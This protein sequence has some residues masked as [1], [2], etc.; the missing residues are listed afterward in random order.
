MAPKLSAQLVGYDVTVWCHHSTDDHR[1]VAAALR[2]IFKKFVFQKEACPTT[3]THHWQIR[4]HLF[5]KLC[6]SSMKDMFL[7]SLWNGCVSPTTTGIHKANNFSYC[8]KIDSRVEGPWTDKDEIPARPPLTRQLRE[9]LDIGPMPWHLT[10]KQYAMELDN[11]TIHV[12][13]ARGNVCKSLW[14]EWMEFQGLGFEIP[15]LSNMEDIMQCAMSVPTYKCYFIDMPR[16]LTKDRLAG[17]YSGIE[18]LKNGVMY[19]KRYAFKKRRI[20]RPQVIVFTN[21]TPVFS[22]LSLDRWRIHNIREDFTLEDVT[23]L[24]ELS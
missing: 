8:M 3:G 4:G 1:E 23:A 15:Y 7:S 14:V 18:C 13:L 16:A 5:E 19:D 12:I 9:F 6:I 10:A 20:D 22:L 2:E 11:R 17:F 21:T 24:Y